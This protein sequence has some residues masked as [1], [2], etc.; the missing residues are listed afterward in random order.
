M[1]RDMAWERK[2][3]LRYRGWEIRNDGI[4]HRASEK[5]HVRT[6][7]CWLELEELTPRRVSIR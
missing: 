5:Y 6:S 7:L 2:E 4:R 3:T 1:K